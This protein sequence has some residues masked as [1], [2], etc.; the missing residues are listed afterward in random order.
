MWRA[1]TAWAVS[2]VGSAIVVLT[3]ATSRDSNAHCTGTEFACDPSSVL[4]A[5]FAQVIIGPL[6]ALVLLIGHVVIVVVGESRR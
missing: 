5:V 2:V 6:A 1:H 3:L 4:G